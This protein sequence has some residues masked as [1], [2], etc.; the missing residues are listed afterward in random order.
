MFQTFSE[1]MEYGNSIIIFFQKV[2]T[3]YRN[4]II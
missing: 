4:P 1:K 2:Y 3:Y